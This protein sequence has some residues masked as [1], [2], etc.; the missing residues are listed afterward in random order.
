MQT[1][2]DLELIL[3]DDGSQDLSGRICEDYADKDNRVKVIHK[4]NGAVQQ[5]MLVCHVVWESRWLFEI[6]MIMLVLIG[7]RKT[8]TIESPK[9]LYETIY[10][11]SSMIGWNN[12][13]V[14]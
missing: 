8:Q 5:G 10:N 11:C 13:L 6:L 14:L 3:I 12:N 1:F 9:C 4:N 7:S 2:T